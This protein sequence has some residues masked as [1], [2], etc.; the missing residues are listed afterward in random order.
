MPRPAERPGQNAR[1]TDDSRS[2]WDREAETFDDA[3]IT[4]PVASFDV[5]LARHVLWAMPD[6]AVALA[7]WVELLRRNGVLIPIEGRWHTGAGLTSAEC[8]GLLRQVRED[9][10]WQPLDDPSY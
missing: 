7:T 6:P 2:L 10:E 3:P 9:V 4:L 8:A 5:V 1:V